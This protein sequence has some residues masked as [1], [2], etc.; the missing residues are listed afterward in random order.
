[1]L[2]AGFAVAWVGVDVVDVDV[3]RHGLVAGPR[4][5]GL[6]WDPGLLVQLPQGRLCQG[7]VVGFGV[8]AWS[9]YLPARQVQHV[10]DAAEGVD[11][12]GAAGDVSGE[13]GAAGDVGGPVEGFQE[14]A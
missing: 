11:D 6:G 13:G 14:A 3:E 7:L 9:E 12:D 10:Q 8:S 1:M 2:V 4:C 5:H